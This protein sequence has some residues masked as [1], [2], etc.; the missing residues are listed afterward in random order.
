M[1]QIK[2]EKKEINE[3]LEHGE[4]EKAEEIKKDIAWKKA[5]DKS[6]G[7]K[8]RPAIEY[9]IIYCTFSDICFFVAFF[10]NF[11]QV[12]DNTALLH[13][14]IHKRAVEKKKS[15][16]EWKEREQKKEKDI[17]NRQKKREANLAKKSE[18]KKKN[19]LKNATKRGRVI[20]GY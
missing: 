5:F 13:K 16:L 17:E 15:K 2:D 11:V 9:L 14:A 3:L 6:D 4:V 7:K 12:K 8:V 10:F 1:K 19:K 18:G 20:P